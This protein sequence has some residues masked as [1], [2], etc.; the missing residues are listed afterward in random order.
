MN[1]EGSEQPEPKR[2]KKRKK[3]KRS[4]KQAG[5]FELIVA[6]FF[7]K[8][9]FLLKP[10]AVAA[11]A[12]LFIF[13]IMLVMQVGFQPFAWRSQ[14]QYEGR[15]TRKWLELEREGK[16]RKAE[17]LFDG[18]RY[19]SPDRVIGLDWEA[20]PDIFE[21]ITDDR[22]RTLSLAILKIYKTAPG[23]PV[24]SDLLNGYE[25]EDPRV[26]LWAVK[27]S[28]RIEDPS[29]IS[30]ATS[31]LEGLKDDPDEEVQLAVDETLQILSAK[32]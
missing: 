2:R 13:C 29:D 9:S 19:I 4:R 5:T 15:T 10:L 24:T 23:T 3:K 22:T 6:D 31:R 16:A 1:Q 18:K 30:R 11:F 20:V 7:A 8:F 28:E 25:S 26:R 14:V 17:V 21:G 32:T 12:A 27:L